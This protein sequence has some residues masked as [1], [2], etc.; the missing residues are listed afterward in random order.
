MVPC[1]C[2]WAGGEAWGEAWWY[3]PKAYLGRQNGGHPL[4]AP[5]SSPLGP[6]AVNCSLTAL[7]SPWSGDTGEEAHEPL[8][9]ASSGH[10][11]SQREEGFV[12]RVPKLKCFAEIFTH[13]F[14][15]TQLRLGSADWGAWGDVWKLWLHNGKEG[16]CGWRPHALTGNLGHVRPW[17]KC[18]SL[19]YSLATRMDQQTESQS[20]STGTF[21]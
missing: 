15:V 10:A 7:R 6:R 21:L 2:W 17:A 5:F 8:P 13:R 1:T 4:H 19:N 18:V 3:S 16:Q 9:A 20:C 11:F 14:W 12:S